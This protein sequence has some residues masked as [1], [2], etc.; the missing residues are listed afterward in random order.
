MSRTSKY[1]NQDTIAGLQS[2]Q[3]EKINREIT[4][5]LDTYNKMNMYHFEY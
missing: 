1:L 5:Y 2:F 4:D 3:I